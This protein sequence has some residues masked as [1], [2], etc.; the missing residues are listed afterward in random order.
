[1]P[2]RRALHRINEHIRSPKLRVIGAAGENLGIITLEE[3]RKLAEEAGVDLVEITAE[4][5][6]P[7]A[8]ITEYG[9]FLYEL[10]KKRKKGGSKKATETKSVQVKIGTSEHDL[11][12]KAK[13]A[14]KWLSEGHRIKV[15]LYLSGRAKY[16]D[17]NFLK[18][19]LLRILNLITENYKIAEDYKKG[20]K[21]IMLMIERQK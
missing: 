16:L 4:A 8:K 19:R 20:P 2:I 10:E 13:T 5:N 9:K 6:P 7:V 21:G 17:Q 1:M 14:S 18:G 12:L 15:E 3:A 11:A